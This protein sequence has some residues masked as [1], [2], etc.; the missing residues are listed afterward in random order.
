MSSNKRMDLSRLEVGQLLF[1]N[2]KA[3]EVT[4]FCV[5]SHPC[6]CSHT[7]PCHS[8]TASLIKYCRM[9]RLPEVRNRADLI[10]QMDR[11]LGSQQVRSPPCQL[12]SCSYSAHRMHVA[13]PPSLWV[14]RVGT[15]MNEEREP[16]LAFRHHGHN[17][18]F[19]W[20]WQVSRL[21]E[22][23]ESYSLSLSL[24]LSPSLCVTHALLEVVTDVELCRLPSSHKL[25]SMRGP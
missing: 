13:D 19:L 24:S 10:H 7:C 12:Y 21:R 22:S 9:Y 20:Q 1:R 2:W 14:C 17:L 15:C 6:P 16:P 11:H 5:P 25:T 4:R 18:H 23:S 3:S 8:Q